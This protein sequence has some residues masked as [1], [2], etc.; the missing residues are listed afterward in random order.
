MFYLVVCI[1]KKADI[2]FIADASTSI[3]IT[4]FGKLKSF[5]KKV[6]SNFEIGTDKIQIGLVTFSNSSKTE[7]PLKAYRYYI[8]HCLNIKTM[9]WH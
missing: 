4:D 2:I 8:L 6:I 7:F 9:Q 3:G 1:D 5:M